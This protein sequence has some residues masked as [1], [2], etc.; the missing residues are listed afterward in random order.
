MKLIRIYLWV[1]KQN[2]HSAVSG[3]NGALALIGSSCL[4]LKF[5]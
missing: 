2:T 5:A 1:I 3:T 4:W